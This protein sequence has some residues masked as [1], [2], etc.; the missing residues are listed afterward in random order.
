MREIR[1][2]ELLEHYRQL[3]RLRKENEPLRLGKLEFFQAGDQKLGFS[4]YCDGKKIRVYVNRS[5]DAWEVPSGKLL[6]G[7]KLRTVA[8]TWLSL[9]PMGFCVM[10]DL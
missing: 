5:S 2:P 7:H 3:G 1:D 8:P 9:S 6:Y 4:R 10:E